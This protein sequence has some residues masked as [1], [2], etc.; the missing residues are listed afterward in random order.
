MNITESLGRPYALAG[1]RL[2]AMSAKNVDGLQRTRML[3][4]GK[5]W[6]PDR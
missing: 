2:A 1:D 5:Q 3:A 6:G 4:M